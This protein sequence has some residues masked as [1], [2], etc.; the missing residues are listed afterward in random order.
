MTS[1]DTGAAPVKEYLTYT[2]EYVIPQSTAKWA[3]HNREVY[4]VGALSSGLNLNYKKLSPMAQKVAE[5][6]DLKPMC[7]NPFMNS[8]AQLVEVVNSVE[9][10]IRLINELRSSG[11]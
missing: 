3:K 11:T 10:S 5:M 9:D 7:H 1:T 4:M 8:I 6:F 2:N